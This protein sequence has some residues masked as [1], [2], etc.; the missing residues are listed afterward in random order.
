V[1]DLESLAQANNPTLVQSSA[2]VE[3]SRGATYQARLLPFDDYS[4]PMTKEDMRKINGR[5][6][7][8][9]MREGWFKS[10]KGL[11]TVMRV[12]PPDLYDKVMNTDE[13]IPPNSS[14]SL[15]PPP[16]NQKL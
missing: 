16:G 3:A 11:F 13:P 10:V 9:G 15:N 14:T 5:R 4:M 1:S 7:V 12:L 6:E 8:Q 2:Q